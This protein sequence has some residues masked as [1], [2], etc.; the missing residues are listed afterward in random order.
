MSPMK[1]EITGKE[2]KNKYGKVIYKY[3]SKGEITG[4]IDL[5]ELKTLNDQVRKAMED[6]HIDDLV[7]FKSSIFRLDD[8]KY[9]NSGMIKYMKFVQEAGEVIG[10]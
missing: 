4:P 1:D 8:V 10:R 6:G 7:Q 2:I 5:G 3:V 9:N